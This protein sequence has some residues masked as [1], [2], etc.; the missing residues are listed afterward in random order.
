[1][2]R[3]FSKRQKFIARVMSGNKCQKCGA[4]LDKNYHADHKKPYVKGGKTILK[5]I[6]A[7]CVNCNLRKGSK[8]ED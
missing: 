4:S 2:N 6:Q 8:I 1:M 5:N 3:L 7:L